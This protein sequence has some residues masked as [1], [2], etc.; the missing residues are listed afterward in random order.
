MSLDIKAIQEDI[1]RI[2]EKPTF[3]RDPVLDQVSL[4]ITVP[5][6]ETDSLVTD[7]L[8][9]RV[10]PG[11]CRYSFSL[12]MPYRVGGKKDDYLVTPARTEGFGPLALFHVG[13]SREEGPWRQR[14]EMT[15]EAAEELTREFIRNR[16]GLL[17]AALVDVV[18]ANTAIYAKPQRAL[19]GWPLNA[20]ETTGNL[21]VIDNL[22]TRLYR[23]NPR[24]L[25]EPHPD[26]EKAAKRLRK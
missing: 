26:V 7:Q 24:R 17:E 4:Q 13:F 3:S 22:A 1:E 10:I 16:P 19:R 20:F 5:R 14:K 8:L 12:T 21:Y 11:L 9:D 6:I 2:K 23:G 25:L 18:G 15:D